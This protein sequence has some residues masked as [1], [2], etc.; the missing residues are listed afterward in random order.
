MVLVERAEIGG[1]S[2][3]DVPISIGE[4]ARRSAITLL[5]RMLDDHT[6]PALKEMRK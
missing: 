4:P 2:D 3:S 6:S 1:S 5:E